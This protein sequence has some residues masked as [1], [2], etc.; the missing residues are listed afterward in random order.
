MYE[1]KPMSYN[2]REKNL[3]GTVQTNI[4]QKRKDIIKIDSI[5]CS[6][7]KVSVSNTV[8]LLTFEDYMNNC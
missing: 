1:R 8:I 7:G 4:S 5:K 2:T 3:Y 6:N